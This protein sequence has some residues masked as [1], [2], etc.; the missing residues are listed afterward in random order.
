MF[1]KILLVALLVLS[2]TAH[3]DLRDYKQL[4]QHAREQREGRGE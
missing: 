2:F 1:K 3:A 4:K